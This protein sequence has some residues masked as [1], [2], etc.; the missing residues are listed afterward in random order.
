VL[1]LA[2]PD[3]ELRDLAARLGVLRFRLLDVGLAGLA[4]AE[5]D[6]GQPQGL[7]LGI[8]VLARDAQTFLV[9]ADVDVGARHLGREAYQG[10]VVAGDRGQEAGVRGFDGASELAPEIQLPAR[11]EAELQDPEAVVVERRQIAPDPA[12]LRDIAAQA[13]RRLAVA[14]ALVRQLAVHLLLLRIQVADRGAQLRA[15]LQDPHAGRLHSGVLLLRDPDQLRQLGIV[16]RPPPLGV[17]GRRGLDPRVIG[18]QPVRRH[19]SIGRHV[20]RPHLDAP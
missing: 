11:A 17:L 16:E 7:A 8:G 14:E 5:L 19:G 12:S 20:V 10:I 13:A 4:V 3:L 2:R 18:C 9:G 6:V 15:R 1:I